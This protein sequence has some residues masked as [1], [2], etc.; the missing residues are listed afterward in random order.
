MTEG[1]L[2]AGECLSFPSLFSG[3]METWDGKGEPWS[4]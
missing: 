1:A 2:S 4:Q 3:Q